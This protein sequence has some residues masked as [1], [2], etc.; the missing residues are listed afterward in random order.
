MRRSYKS[1]SKYRL[2]ITRLQISLDNIRRSEKQAK[3]LGAFM[4]K[5]ED[6]RANIY[7][8]KSNQN[9]IAGSLSERTVHMTT[10][11]TDQT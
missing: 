8:I 3:E 5:K 2:E 7:E 9:S 11:C 10:M 1:V 4:P 6:R